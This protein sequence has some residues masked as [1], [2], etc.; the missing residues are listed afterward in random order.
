MS[1]SL[2]AQTTSIPESLGVD[3]L[4]VEPDLPRG[5]AGVDV[6][7]RVRVV[8]GSAGGDVRVDVRV[9]WNVASVGR[10]ADAPARGL[11]ARRDR[12]E[13]RCQEEESKSHK[14]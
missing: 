13:E 7:V 1:K 10:V 6:Q 3:V 12:R 14:D 11:G 8:G 2:T 4:S 9:R 5:H